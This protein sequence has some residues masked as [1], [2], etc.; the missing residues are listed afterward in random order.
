MDSRNI[1][2]LM[3]PKVWLFQTLFIVSC[4]QAR[5][6]ESSFGVTIQS[7][8]K[9]WIT[10]RERAIQN[11]L[12]SSAQVSTQTSTSLDDPLLGPPLHL[13]KY[14]E[15]PLYYFRPTMN[16][17]TST[18]NVF[19]VERVSQRLGIYHISNLLSAEECQ[20]LTQPK[21]EFQP[22]EV[23]GEFDNFRTKSSVSWIYTEENELYDE[24]ALCL[25]NIF[26]SDH[27][28]S[29]PGACVE[30][31]QV[32]HYEKQ[33]GEFK[34]HHDGLGRVITILYYLN[35]V[36][37]TWFPFAGNDSYKMTNRNEALDIIHTHNLT[38]GKDGMLIVGKDDFIKNESEYDADHTVII[39]PG[40]AVVFYNYLSSDD[41]TKY[42]DLNSI[43]AGMPTTGQEKW[44]ANHWFHDEPF[45]T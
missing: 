23:T 40:D 9:S 7:S 6:A 11:T 27:V 26:L 30:P 16:G 24:L 28:K 3:K 39:K 35:G 32:V 15:E 17:A 45:S 31:L 5:L 12:Y 25:G 41:G 43:H 33:G 14:G 44:I 2:L 29:R 20:I 21:E 18:E 37:G 34:F 22:A 13:P 19:Q 38:P 8:T 10:Q 42:A 1:I 4:F 36:A